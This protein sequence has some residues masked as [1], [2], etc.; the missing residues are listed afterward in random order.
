MDLDS[1]SSPPRHRWRLDATV[2]G[3]AMFVGLWL[4]EA[5][6]RVSPVAPPPPVTQVAQSP[7]P[8]GTSGP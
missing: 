1:P 7:V 4:G 3:I 8:A 5:A 2:V 6:P